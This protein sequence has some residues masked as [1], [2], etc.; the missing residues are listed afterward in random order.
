VRQSID[1]NITTDAAGIGNREPET[2]G[3]G[4]FQVQLR[5]EESWTNGH[6]LANII[7]H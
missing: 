1:A 7:M 3:R 6:E 2:K 4:V 5:R